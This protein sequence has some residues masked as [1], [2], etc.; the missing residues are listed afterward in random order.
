MLIDETKL[1]HGCNLRNGLKSHSLDN[2]RSIT[3]VIA[4]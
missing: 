4:T 3:R 1:I 2:L